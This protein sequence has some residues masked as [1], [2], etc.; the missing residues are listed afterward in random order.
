[1]VWIEKW[2]KAWSEKREYLL[3]LTWLQARYPV[4]LNEDDIW[5]KG[6]TL[7]APHSTRLLTQTKSGRP[8]AVPGL[9]Y[10]SWLR[11][12]D[13]FTLTPLFPSKPDDIILGK[14][15]FPFPYSSSPLSNR[16][17]FLLLSD[18]DQ[19]PFSEQPRYLAPRVLPS[20]IPRWTPCFCYPIDPY[21]LPGP[22]QTYL[23]NPFFEKWT[24]RDFF[25]K[26]S[27]AEE[28]PIFF[29]FPCWKWKG[30]AEEVELNVHRGLAYVK[31]SLNFK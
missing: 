28:N 4:S 10:R 12:S 31:M 19:G 6:L 23:L 24:G 25:S 30:R 14:G 22:D 11:R 13:P 3:F 15:R 1:M 26:I 17:F 8:K 27:L 9:L 18:G 29:F 16:R 7:W 5:I 20:I 21:P 2:V